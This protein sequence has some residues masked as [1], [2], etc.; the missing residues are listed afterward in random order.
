MLAKLLA[1]VL[2][3]SVDTLIAA[4]ALGMRGTGRDTRLRA[5]ALLAGF[6]AGMPLVGLALGAPLGHLIGHAAD[7]AAVGLL[8]LL[9]G[10]ALLERDS[11][12]RREPVG[13]AEI[14]GI[15]ALLLGLSVSVDE[16][17]VGFTLGLL[18]VNVVLVVALIAIQAVIA[19]QVGLRV[20]G[21]LGARRREAAER[22]AAL[23]FIVLAL[24]MLVEAVAA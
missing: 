5:T 22:L 17:L 3:L 16:L 20:G 2:P 23:A 12:E 15:G 1:L 18:R 24:V 14:R 7:Y 4:A 21:R 13:P 6:E 19:T 11:D 9:G 8:L 10:H